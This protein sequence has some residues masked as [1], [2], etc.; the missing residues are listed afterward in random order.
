SPGNEQGILQN[1]DP[2]TGG[3]INIGTT[4]SL[5]AYD[6][7]IS[8]SPVDVTYVGIDNQELAAL[9]ATSQAGNSF[10]T[11]N[12]SVAALGGATGPTAS[13]R[14]LIGQF[15]TNGTFY[16]EFNIQIG[17]PTGGVQN[18]V[19]RNPTGNEIQ[20]PAL[21]YNYKLDLK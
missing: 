20:L 5:S 4:T 16:F 2:S 12:G 11:S 19:A 8:G 3:P 13:N 9:D 1:N 18:Y 7:M 10:I 17:T 6:G 14:V 15:T 21:I